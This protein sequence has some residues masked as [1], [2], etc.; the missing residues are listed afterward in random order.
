[1]DEIADAKAYV[2]SKGITLD[3]VALSIAV[4]A[5]TDDTDDDPTNDERS[6]I[7]LRREVA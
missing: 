2:E 1:M 6:V 3:A 5:T 7:P 4:T